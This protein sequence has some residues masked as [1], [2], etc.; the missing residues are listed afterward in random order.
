MN[1]P[2]IVSHDEWL[3][4]RKRLLAK[5]KDFTRARDGLNTERRRLP[6]V[7]IDKEYV[8]GGPDGKATL[9]DLF[10]GRRQLIVYHFMFDPARDAGC[11]GCSIVVD[12]I[13]HL[14]HLHARDT[15][16]VLVSRA[17]LPKLL[18]YQKRMGWTVPWYSSYGSEFNY[19]FN[20]TGDESVAP[21]EYNYRDQAELLAMGHDG[22]GEGHGLSAFL[23]GE[24]DVC[25]TYSTYA[26]GTD[27]L[28]STFNYLD[29]TALGR[30][31][32]W[33][34]P[35]GRSW[36]PAS[37]W[38]WR[39]HDEYEQDINNSRSMPWVTSHLMP[40]AGPHAPNHTVRRS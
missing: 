14:A 8:F 5:E 25:H 11:E 28:N 3:G 9:F 1:L 36:L 32:P 40:S 17:P 39:R 10:D 26:R 24:A 21:V 37:G 27:L 19:D 4:A 31:E 12:N 2:K 18:A 34:E 15:S 6:M 7:R 23:C 33:E 30:Q 20:V 16:L 13:G 38:W 22:T 35:P 29:L